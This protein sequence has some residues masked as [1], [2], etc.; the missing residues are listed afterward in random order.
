MRYIFGIDIGATKSKILLLDK[1]GKI[2]YREKILT[3]SFDRVDPIIERASRR[4]EEIIR[5]KKIKKN[6]IEL[7]GVGL[8]GQLDPQTGLVDNSPNLRWFGVQFGKRFEERLGIKIRLANDVNAA[9]W[10][11]YVFGFKKRAKDIVAVFVGS[12]IGGGFVCNGTLVEGSTGTAAEI[13]HMIFKKDGLLCDCGH[14]GCFEVYGAG[15]PMEKRMREAVKKG[16]SPMVEEMVKG[17]LAKIN[18]RTIATAA[19]R[20]DKMAK[21]IWK[22][23]EEALCVLCANLVSMLNPE[24]LVLGGGVIEGNPILVSTI[25]SFVKKE[26]V[27]LSARNVKIVKSML[28]GDAVA[29]GAAALVELVS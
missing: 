27:E 14:R 12:G 22:D 20:G 1:K 24:V 4:I 8:A 15:M 19:R 13:G 2:I 5:E 18:T 28:K 3:E 23:A 16:K 6:S 11:E 25:R 21:A 17:D 10:G 26:A 29:L 7:V 9:A